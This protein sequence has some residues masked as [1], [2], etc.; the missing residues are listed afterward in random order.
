MGIL[1]RVFRRVGIAT[2]NVNCG[3][4]GDV[5]SGHLIMWTAWALALYAA[6]YYRDGGS[7]PLPRK[8]LLVRV[9]RRCS[10][11]WDRAESRSWALAR[12]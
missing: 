3:A 5:P 1:S 12:P 9:S 8:Y 6:F 2:V 10:V 4:P 7:S 11:Q